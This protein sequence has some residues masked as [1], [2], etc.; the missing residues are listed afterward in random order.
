MARGRVARLT[1][2]PD[3]ANIATAS[4]MGMSLRLR[5]GLGEIDRAK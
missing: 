5:R 4:E 1:D 2:D 3:L